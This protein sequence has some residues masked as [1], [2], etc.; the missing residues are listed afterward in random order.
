LESNE[1]LENKTSEEIEDSDIVTLVSNL[2][3]FVKK[4]KVKEYIRKWIKFN[5]NDEEAEESINAWLQGDSEM[6]PSRKK[7]RKAVKLLFSAL[8]MYRDF[9]VVGRFDRLFR[10]GRQ[11]ADGEKRWLA[12]A[13]DEGSGEVRRYYRDDWWGDGSPESYDHLLNYLRES[14]REPRGPCSM[15]DAAGNSVGEYYSTYHQLYDYLRNLLYEKEGSL[16]KSV[17]LPLYTGPAFYGLA[18]APIGGLEEEFWDDERGRKEFRRA[19]DDLRQTIDKNIFPQLQ[20]LYEVSFLRRMTDEIAECM[21][22]KEFLEAFCKEVN[23]LGRCRTCSLDNRV[24]SWQDQESSEQ[25][26]SPLLFSFEESEDE[27]GK[28]D[29]GQVSFKVDRDTEN[30]GKST[31]KVGISKNHHRNRGFFDQKTKAQLQQH[32]R[33]VQEQFCER[34]RMLGSS[35]KAAVA[36][37]MSRNMSHNIGSHVSPRA[38]LDKIRERLGEDYDEETKFEIA[39]QLKARLDDLI[40]KKADFLAEITT[41]PLATTKPAFFYREVILPFVENTL[42]TDNIARNEGMGY[43]D[44]EYGE[45]KKKAVGSNALQISVEI[46]GEPV[47]A[48]YKVGD[49]RVCSVEDLPYSTHNSKGKQLERHVASDTPDVEVALPGPLGEH[50][51]YGFLENFIRN[52][53]K[54]HKGQLELQGKRKHPEDHPSVKQKQPDLEKP[55]SLHEWKL[56]RWGKKRLEVQISITD[57]EENP[58][59]YNVEVSTNLWKTNSPGFSEEDLDTLYQKLEGAGDKDRRLL[60]LD[61]VREDGTLRRKAWGLAELKICANLLRGSGDYSRTSLN[62]SLRLV[63]NELEN[64]EKELAYQLQ[65]MKSKQVCVVTSRVER[66]DELEKRGIWVFSSVEELEKSLDEVDSIESY[67]FALI[68]CEGDCSEAMGELKNLMPQLPFRV[69]L[70]D[71]PDTWPESVQELQELVDQRRVV[72][73]DKHDANAIGEKLDGTQGKAKE[74]LAW[75]WQQWVKH[76]FLKKNGHHQD[77]LLDLYFEQEYNV[78]PTKG[79]LNAGSR[80]NRNSEQDSLHTRVWLRD[81]RNVRTSRGFDAEAEHDRHVMYDRHGSALEKIRENT[82]LDI[83]GMGVHPYIFIDKKSPDFTNIYSPTFPERDYV[84]NW[85]L[86]WELCEA[87]LLRVLV[88]DERIAE[89][90]FEKADNK[91]KSRKVAFGY[92]E[93]DTDRTPRRMEVAWASEVY[94]CTHLGI[95]GSEREA[96]HKAVEK[97]DKTTSENDD[98]ASPHLAVELNA[99]DEH[100]VKCSWQLCNGNS[101]KGLDS[102]D[103]L[104]IHQGILDNFVQEGRQEEMLQKVREQIPYVIVDSGRGIPNTLCDDVKFMPFSLIQDYMMGNRIGKHSFTRIAMSL[105][106]KQSKETHSK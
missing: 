86:P 103:M 9:D 32:F 43:D 5:S 65:L 40:Q 106:R 79:W 2:G 12:I 85:S 41:E 57:D 91:I 72:V 66:S 92:S 38:K 59:F 47:S 105:I 97:R 58:E 10:N 7:R 88:I 64:G 42:L 3:S 35:R 78:Q 93:D 20:S 53:A 13:Y 26:L 45:G 11:L 89:R 61:L 74:F 71:P 60:K 19:A 80:F 67:K 90:S 94:T 96:I 87:G 77:A 28:A 49:S 95:D 68:D 81:H 8:P 37:I 69:L 21:A 39:T 33:L 14:E 6:P 15:G 44:E 46:N 75:L 48:C 73:L 36:A 22:Y 1:E 25:E 27:S 70:A 4:C 99:D 102:L 104:I 23:F 62:K 100:P 51:F 17:Y 101:G 54:H 18:Y 84:V 76:R 63:K 29:S 16:A 82:S 30:G 83:D 56:E 98:L 52:V 34:M 50:A 31:L 24:W 55:F